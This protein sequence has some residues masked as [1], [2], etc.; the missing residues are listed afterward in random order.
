MDKHIIAVGATATYR[1]HP[2]RSERVSLRSAE[3]LQQLFLSQREILHSVTLR[4]EWQA[5][6]YCVYV[7]WK[8]IVA[9]CDGINALLVAR[10]F[11]FLR[12][13]VSATGSAH[14]RHPER[15]EGSLCLIIIAIIHQPAEMTKI[16]SGRCEH[17][18]LHHSEWQ[19]IS[20]IFLQKNMTA[21]RCH[22]F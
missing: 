15:S 8:V 5:G 11:P 16:L 10:N 13:A 17:R 18:P 3:Q 7:P 19:I 21:L 20:K 14:L 12:F 1:C 2:E 4:S 22:I 9:P 6:I